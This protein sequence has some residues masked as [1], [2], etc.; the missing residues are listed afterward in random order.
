MPSLDLNWLQKLFPNPECSPI[1][2]TIP[3]GI[4]GVIP[5]D[6]DICKHLAPMREGLSYGWYSITALTI[7]GMFLKT[8]PEES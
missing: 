1:H 3:M 4:A 5:M 8:K 2:L 7:A 6:I